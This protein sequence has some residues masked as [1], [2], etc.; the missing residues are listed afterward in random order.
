MWISRRVCLWRQVT[1][2]ERVQCIPVLFCI[3]IPQTNSSRSS[4]LK[5]ETMNESVHGAYNTSDLYSVVAAAVAASLWIPASFPHFVSFISSV[6]RIC[7]SEASHC[8]LSSLLSVSCLFLHSPSLSSLYCLHAPSPLTFNLSAA[9]P[10]LIPLYV[11]I[12]GTLKPD[13]FVVVVLL[14]DRSEDL[15]FYIESDPVFTP[16][17]SSLQK[18]SKSAVCSVRL[19]RSESFFVF[20]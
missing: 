16:N 10:H 11:V 19:V 6:W 2:C 20:F 13:L 14:R 18:S 5:L 9:D 17:L 4:I 3:L 7:Q 1:D 8:F 12:R 15:S